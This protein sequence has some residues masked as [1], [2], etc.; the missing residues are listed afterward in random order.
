MMKKELIKVG[1]QIKD[2]EIIIG[3]DFKN[4]WKKQM[5]H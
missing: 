1:N 4:K 3:E 5:R 2:L